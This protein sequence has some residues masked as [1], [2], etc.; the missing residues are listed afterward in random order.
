VS[1][2][3]SM[4]EE[5]IEKV[6]TYYAE[7]PDTDGFTHMAIAASL[8]RTDLVRFLY[9]EHKVNPNQHVVSNGCTPTFLSA[10]GG[11]NE[12]IECLVTEC[13]ANVNLACTMGET[14][15]FIATRENLLDTVKLLIRLGADVNQVMYDGMTVLHVAV[16]NSHDSIAKWL[17]KHG[18]ADPSILLPIDGTPFTASDIAYIYGN[19]EL[20]RRLQCARPDCKNAGRKKCSGCLKERY[21]SRECQVLHW[22]TGHR[23]ECRKA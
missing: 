18:G 17:V 12:T 2:L 4:W 22:N 13:G 19:T 20:S 9:Q 3:H 10:M 16:L 6:R 5:D 7:H 11:Y 21:C 14:P 15:L 8:G 23:K 1:I